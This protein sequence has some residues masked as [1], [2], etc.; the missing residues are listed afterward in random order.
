MAN[1]P[2]AAE[3][4]AREAAR[5]NAQPLR[6]ACSLCEWEYIGTTGKG[7]EEASKHRLE[8]HPELP[9]KRH[10]AIRRSSFRYPTMDEED[11]A[12]I[13]SER[14]KRARLHGLELES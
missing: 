7:R 4:R 6:T 10:R 1:E 5:S 9:K 13:D 14:Q 12:L 3:Y 8:A 11:K 2:P